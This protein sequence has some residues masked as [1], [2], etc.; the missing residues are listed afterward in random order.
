MAKLFITGA[1]GFIGG[2]IVKHALDADLEVYAAVRK[3]SNT[4]DLQKLGITCL[5]WDFENPSLTKDILKEYQFDY[6][7]YNAGL[8]KHQ[9]QDELNKV[10]AEYVKTFLDAAE[11]ANVQFKKFIYT[12]SLASYGPAEGSAYGIIDS[13]MTP[14]PVT[15]YGVSKLK[16]EK[17]IETY[18]KLPYLIYRPT[19]VYGPKEQDLFA[20][21]Q[22]INK[23]LE[24][25]LGAEKQM[26]SFIYVEDLARLLIKGLFSHA[27]RKGYFVS[28]GNTYTSDQLNHYIKSYLN[29]KTISVT[30]PVGLLKVIS[31]ISEGMGKLTKSYPIL[32]QD[33]LNELTAKSWIC[34]TSECFEDSDFVPDYPLHKGVPLTIDWYRQ[35]N[36]L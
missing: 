30:L 3:S 8:T 13:R 16:A 23:G 35:N 4:S 29:R 31:I 10:N 9:S 19:A 17:I 25:K 12:S 20:V 2:F 36:W 5:P 1:T 24:V 33:K 21:F 7:I 15:M 34:D 6:V 11:E 27:E 28:D 14:K 18:E 26:L 22:M 32:N